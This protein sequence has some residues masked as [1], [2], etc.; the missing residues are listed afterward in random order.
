LALWQQLKI[1]ALAVAVLGISAEPAFAYID[2]GTGSILLQSVIGAISGA[3]V[4]LRLYWT[5]IRRFFSKS[6]TDEAT[7]EARPQPQERE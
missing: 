7:P 3:L 6:R 1:I 2:P 4:L 5:R